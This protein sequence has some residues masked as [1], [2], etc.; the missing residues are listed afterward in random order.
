MREKKEKSRWKK[1]AKSQAMRMA[2]RS[3]EKQGNGFSL[4]ASRKE[5]SPADTLV[6]A[7]ADSD[8]TLDLTRLCCF[9][10][11]RWWQSVTTAIGNSDII[12]LNPETIPHIHFLP[13]SSLSS[14]KQWHAGTVSQ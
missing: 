13:F 8:Q 6:L 10:P 1:R 2:R 12:H 7:Q 3:W 11:L 9:M 4:T 5:C 14:L